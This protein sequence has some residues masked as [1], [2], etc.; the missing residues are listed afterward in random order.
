M[1]TLDI[2]IDVFSFISFLSQLSS[3]YEESLVF[4]RLNDAL[5]EGVG[6]DIAGPFPKPNL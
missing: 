6:G 4:Y 2:F 5:N 3:L 1:C